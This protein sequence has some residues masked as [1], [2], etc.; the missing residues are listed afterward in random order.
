MVSGGVWDTE[1]LEEDVQELFRCEDDRTVVVRKWV[2]DV[3][4]SAFKGVAKV[5]GDGDLED[6]NMPPWTR[7]VFW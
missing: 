1:V 3:R 7:N 2:T 4:I 5:C 6:D